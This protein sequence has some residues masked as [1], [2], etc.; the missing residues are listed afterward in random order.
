[1]F[2]LLLFFFPPAQ[3]TTASWLKE[4][5]LPHILLI[6]V[7]GWTSLDFHQ[8]YVTSCILK[9]KWSLALQKVILLIDSG[10]PVQTSHHRATI[11]AAAAQVED[12]IW[13]KV[14]LFD[15]SCPT[16]EEMKVCLVISYSWSISCRNEPNQ[17]SMSFFPIVLERSSFHIIIHTVLLASTF[18]FTVNFVYLQTS[19][20]C[21]EGKHC[22][23]NLHIW[24]PDA[25]VG[26]QFQRLTFILTNQILKLFVFCSNF[27]LHYRWQDSWHTVTMT[28]AN[29]GR[30][31][32]IHHSI[33]NMIN[34]EHLHCF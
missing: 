7:V 6:S 3:P 21:E 34:A 22:A 19:V 11:A 32:S 28:E 4:T 24:L 17:G 20:I 10:R 1:M 29:G 5:L 13:I 33:I 31:I 26:K 18:L 12:M 27:E 30:G 9:K 14:Q 8:S 16:V 15:F 23:V 25:R 2:G